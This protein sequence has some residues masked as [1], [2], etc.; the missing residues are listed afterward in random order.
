MTDIVKWSTE[1]GVKTNKTKFSHFQPKQKFIGFLWNGK[2]KK[3][4]LPEKKLAEQI[5]Q[6]REFL[7]LDHQALLNQV[8][9]LA[10]RLNHVS[11]LL[12]QLQCYL[13]LIY[14][15]L[16]N[17]QHK[18]ATCFTPQD[19]REDLH[20]WLD[21]LLSF[22][23][24]RLVA[25]PD[26][27]EIDWVGDAYSLYGVGVLIGSRWSRF[28]AIEGWSQMLIPKRTIAWLKTVAI[29]IG[30]LMLQKLNICQGKMLVVWREGLV[31]NW[32]SND[33]WVNEEWKRIQL[34]LVDIELDL[35]AKRV[36]SAKNK[37]DGLS[38]GDLLGHAA[39]AFVPII[40]PEDLNVWLTEQGPEATPDLFAKSLS[41]PIDKP[42]TVK[43]PPQVPF[44]LPATAKD[45][46]GFVF[47]ANR[48]EE[49]TTR[50]EVAAGTIQK[51][52]FDALLPSRPKKK[53]VKLKHLLFLT[54]ILVKGGPRD[55]AVFDLALVAFWGMAHLAEL[56]YE[57]TTGPLRTAVSLLT[58]DVVLPDKQTDSILFL[59]LWNAKTCKPGEV[60]YI[61]LRP[62]NNLLCP[63]MAVKCR[64]QEARDQNTSLF[65]YNPNKSRRHLTKTTVVPRLHVV[66]H[67]CWSEGGFE[68]ISGHSF[69]VGG[70]SL[71]YAL[72]V[73]TDEICELG[74]W[75]SE[76]YQLYIR[77]FTHAK[78]RRPRLTSSKIWRQ[79]SCRAGESWAWRLVPHSLSYQGKVSWPHLSEDTD[80]SSLSTHTQPG[81][82]GSLLRGVEPF[83][84]FCWVCGAQQPRLLG[85]SGRARN[86]RLG[87]TSPA[88]PSAG[89]LL[90]RN[91]HLY[92]L[93]LLPPA[94]I[95]AAAVGC[96]AGTRQQ[97]I[98]VCRAGTTLELLRPDPATGRLTSLATEHAFASI[99]A[100]A[101]FRLTGAAKDLLILGSDSGRIVVLEFDPA[102]NT[103]IKLHQETFG[104]SGARRVVPG[105]FL[106]TD[107]K[108]RAVMVAAVEKSKLVY[109]LN[110][111]AAAN[112][113]ISS[114]LEAHKS[115]AII[116][117]IVGVD[118]GFENPLFAALEVDYG[119]ADQDPTGEAFNAAEKMLTY[120]ELDLGLNHVV[121]K[122]SEPTEPRANMLLQVPGGQSPSQPDKFDGPSGVIVCCEDML[123]YKHPNVPE[124]RVPIPKRN[125]ALADPAQGLLIVA[126]VMHKMRGAFFFLIQSEQGDLFKVTIDHEDEQVQAL[127]IKYFDTVPVASSLTILKS[128]FLFVAAETGNHALYQFEKLGDDDQ[129]PEFSSASYPD[130][131]ASGVLPGAFFKPRPLENLV[132]SDEL[133]SLA[134]ITG[135]RTLGTS[136]TAQ[137]VTCSGSGARSSVRVLRQGLEVAEI[138]SSA[139][140]G[141]PTNVWTTR[142]SEQ[143]AHDRYIVLGFLNATL[144]LAIG[145][146]IVEV[147]D[148]G[149]LTHAPTIAIQQLD[150]TGLL[151]IHPAGIRHI[152]A[153]GQVTE[154]K[155]PPG[156]TIVA[157]TS[158]RRQVVVGLSGGELIY[159]ELDL[160]GQLNEY[161]EMKQM[162]AAVTSLSLAEVP[163]G[164]Q[165]TPFLAVGLDNATV[166]I[167]SLDPSSVLETISL[168]ALTA[169]PSSICIAELR[170]SSID[171][172]NDTLFV[173]IGLSNGV[174]LRTVL[175][176]VNGQLTDTRTRFL[177][178]RPVKLLR[179][180]VDGKTSV[181]GLSSR[182]WL[183]YTFQNLLHFDPLL[184][185]SLDNVHSFSAELCPEGLIGIVGSSLR[186][187]TI[188]KLGVKVKQ[189]PL[190]LAY[191]PRRMLIDPRTNHVITVE[192]EHR[193]MAP[194]VQADRLALHKA[195]GLDTDTLDPVAFGLPR[196]EAGQ[197][198]SCIRISDPVEKTT[199]ARIDLADNEA[200][201]ALAI[202]AFAFAAHVPPDEPLLV[203]G[204][205]KDAFVQPRTCK[206][207][208]C[209]CIGA[210]IM[211]EKGA[212]MGAPHKLNTLVHFHLND[213]PTAILKTSLVPGGR[214]VLVYT[215]LQGTVGALVPLAAR[216]DVDFFQTLEM[217]MRAERPSLAGRDH[218]AYRGYYFPVKN[219]VDGDLCEAFALLPSHKQLQ[220]AAELD[221]S[222]SDVLKKIEAVRV[223]SAF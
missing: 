170:D 213:I 151:Q 118:V 16:K 143:D 38:R 13:C 178:S 130:N 104:K 46:V 215:G 122:W 57:A 214:D 148:S 90:T 83:E 223:A 91:M 180:K 37:A 220:V 137:L 211:H 114:P 35:V 75:V 98:C 25:N 135:A 53:A 30:L 121:R 159:F 24:T 217:H 12:P 29:R 203:V 93:T 67:R 102:T 85:R 147:A 51:Y 82:L 120:Y 18:K 26:P 146:T 176:S 87:G 36:T 58:S 218:L 123:I 11:M 77:P 106:A 78:R 103:F 65:G 74:R 9:V 207:G 174:L 119:E 219:C 99:R 15:W 205:A 88:V 144:V 112:L 43:T 209:G 128:G 92:N 134:P 222:V 40:L 23:N 45:I 139:L 22:T 197:W 201:T 94:A 10:G 181:I 166:Q 165:R 79:R 47:W 190:P 72:G 31:H 162:G 158:N 163:R 187:F 185:D 149:L 195:Q 2:E 54:K 156:R 71:R 155:T 126:A 124:H 161:Q 101:P 117:H 8:E 125:S 189:D 208:S 6:I 49:Q 199:L 206:A 80:I 5:Q 157:A 73:P 44:L 177:G 111:D 105:Q 19:A 1:L 168:Q 169:V 69:R 41:L 39:A 86:A 27:T 116:H 140:P 221:R 132:S 188:P 142:V 21:T 164:R 113:T 20:F 95:T 70:A 194:G 202:V 33:K 96:F 129:E 179:V 191:T 212:L 200:A 100:L 171:K 89:F 133:E 204:S 109:I 81:I 66:A 61:Q 138:V 160:E 3:V 127:K 52:L 108:G 192:S 62:T 196:A 34:I 145:E 7:R 55:L 32:K 152:L 153:D 193:T 4:R 175:D 64:L 216:E 110:R 198:A 48:N 63:V 97:D 17:W 173:N 186:I 150:G 56:T 14:R 172:N 183:N 107:P 115:N 84:P 60:Q 76:C 182:T 136:E 50:H 131:G 59:R 68:G 184:Y 141:P 28:K 154:W 210:T 42:S 167:I